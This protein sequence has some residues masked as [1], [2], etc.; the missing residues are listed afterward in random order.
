MSELS[1]V[2][3]NNSEPE[4]NLEPMGVIASTEQNSLS[5]T[6]DAETNQLTFDWDAD[7]NPEYNYLLAISTEEIIGKIIR[8]AT[9]EDAVVNTEAE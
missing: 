6:Y 7:K 9:S 8:W 2:I 4:P 1:F 5:C 3:Q